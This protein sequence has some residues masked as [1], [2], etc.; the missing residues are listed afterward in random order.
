MNIFKLQKFAF[1]II[2]LLVS[3]IGQT[4][5][6]K[7]SNKEPIADKKNNCKIM[8]T[9]YYKDGGTNT[10]TLLFQ[11]DNKIKCEKLKKLYSNNFAPARVVKVIVKM[12][13]TKP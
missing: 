13:W 2:I 1:F 10:N 11:T 12:K 3:S 5:P 9:S 7:H 8:V 6:L 4:W